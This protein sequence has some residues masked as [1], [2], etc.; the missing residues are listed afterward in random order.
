MTG[1]EKKQKAAFMALK[2]KPG[3]SYRDIQAYSGV[4]ST[5]RIVDD[6]VKRNLVIIEDDGTHGGYKR[7][8]TKE[9]FLSKQEENALEVWNKMNDT[10]E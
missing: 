1:Q 8:A 7:T 9:E 5:H 3:A 6:L 4:K 2:R 10:D